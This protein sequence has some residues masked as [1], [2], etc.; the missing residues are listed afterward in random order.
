VVALPH[1]RYYLFSGSL[2]DIR[3]S[4]ATHGWTA[5]SIWWP[6]DRSWIVHT[7]VDQDSTYV[8]GSADC[9]A[10]VLA[11]SFIETMPAA[12]GD[13]MGHDADLVNR[14]L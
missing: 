4:F 1:R 8:G 9:V 12:C 6:E 14:L 3:E 11:D 10:S 5:A 2:A 13:R 7:E